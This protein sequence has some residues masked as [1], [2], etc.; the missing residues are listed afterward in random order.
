MVERNVTW[1]AL[2]CLCVVYICRSGT[3]S[4]TAPLQSPVPRET[5]PP[6][7]PAQRVLGRELAAERGGSR[8]CMRLVGEPPPG[9]LPLFSQLK[10]ESTVAEWEAVNFITRLQTLTAGF[11]GLLRRVQCPLRPL[12]E[13]WFL[14]VVVLASG[15][16][17]S[18][19]DHLL[20]KIRRW[21]S[22]G[23]SGS[24][25]FFKFLL[26]FIFGCAGSSLP[27]VFF[28]SCGKQGWLS[29]CG[30]LVLPAV[31]SL[32]AQRGSR[33]RGLQWLWPSGL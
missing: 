30:A 28:P 26:I 2:V 18:W 10:T 32:A 20:P 5:S 23:Q 11:S 12:G 31:A 13:P 25:L 33:A 6:L 9:F 1:L 14:S 4:I 7:N 24:D 8:A 3:P 15:Q 27:C 21:S 22:R 19:S 16:A 29:G 17:S